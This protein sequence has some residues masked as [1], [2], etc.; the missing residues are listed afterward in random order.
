MEW[1]LGG[2]PIRNDYDY[3]EWDDVILDNELEFE[4]VG[5]LDGIVKFLKN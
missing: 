2:R 5:Q 1:L 3:D 4:V